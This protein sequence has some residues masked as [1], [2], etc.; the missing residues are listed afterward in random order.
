MCPE[1]WS[2]GG[3]SDNTI[4]KNYIEHTFL[5]LQEEG[6][7]VQQDSYALFNTGC[8]QS[9]MN[10]F[11]PIS[12]RIKIPIDRFGIWTAFTPLISWV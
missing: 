3:Q 4:L 1:K 7:V 11:S 6:N 2:F 10:R 5:K 9:I 12:P 8:I